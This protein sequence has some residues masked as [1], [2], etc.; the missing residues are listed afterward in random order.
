M[1]SSSVL[2]TQL[3][4]GLCKVF[5][6]S[7]KMMFVMLLISI[8]Y[9]QDLARTSDVNSEARALLHNQRVLW[10]MMDSEN[11]GRESSGNKLGKYRKH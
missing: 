9:E 5:I 4:V 2:H 1:F 10:N 6:F 8:T 7:I 3:K 11:K